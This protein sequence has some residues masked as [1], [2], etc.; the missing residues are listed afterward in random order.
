VLSSRL[1]RLPRTQAFDEESAR[2]GLVFCCEECG[3]FDRARAACR[4]DWPT[5]LH[6]RARYD[7]R[8]TDE[9]VF[10]KEFEAC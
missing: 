9:I 8:D 4:H 2:F 7:E 1:V 6:R 3:H 5:D 10:C